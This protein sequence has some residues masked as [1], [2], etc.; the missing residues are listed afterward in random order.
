MK[1]KKKKK[2]FFYGTGRRKSSVARVR[3]YPGKG[4]IL[5]NGRKFKDYLPVFSLRSKVVAPLKHVGLEG[6]FDIKVKIKGGGIAGQTD[7]IFLGIA[8]A[9]LQYDK[10][11][12]KSLKDA[13]FLT[14]DPRE[15]ERK[16]PGLRRARR[17]PQWRKR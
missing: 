1:V 14:R 11:L 3:L 9:A 2:N 12:K 6:K 5:I 13:G 16:K 7:A 17:A 4:L 10:K 15:K 8:R